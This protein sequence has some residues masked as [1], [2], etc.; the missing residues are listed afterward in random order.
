MLAQ[1]HQALADKI[2]AIANKLR[3]PYRPPQY[4]RVMLP[5]TVL[6]RL[7]CVLEPTKAQVLKQYEALQARGLKGEALDKAL[8]RA[9]A[10]DR[11]QPLYNVSPYTFAKLIGDP[12]GLARNLTAY[13]KGFSP[14]VREIFEKFEF[15]KEIEKL[16][17]A[18][19]LFEVIKIFAALD[20]H[21]DTVPNL[22]MGYVFENLIR[23]F[24]EQA[25][26]E[27]GDH[28]TPREVI[29]LMAHL[30]YT[31]D[32]DIH[33]AGISRTIY[34]PACGT[35]GM[36]SVSEEYIRSSN[37]DAHLTLYGQDYNAEAY[38]ICCADMLIKDEPAD[39]IVHGDT[40]GD[41]KSGDGHAGKTFHYMM[42]NP[43]FGVEW[44]TQEG[45]VKKENADHGFNGRFGPGLPRI[46]DGA[47][48]FLLHMIAKRKPSPDDGGE[49][50]KIAIVFN[51]SPLFTGDAGGGESNI[52]RWIIEND[53]LDAI[54]ALPDQLFYNTGIYT[55]VWMVTNR[56][57][58]KRRGKVQLI[59]ATRHFQK[60]KKSLGNKRNELS[61]EHIAGI[62]RLY[63][64][65]KHDAKAKFASN[66][67]TI[68]RVCSKV[69]DNREF[70]YLKLTIERPLRLNFQASIERILRLKDQSAFRALAESKKRK[71]KAEVEAEEEAGRELQE[72][73]ILAL[74]R[75][76]AK[77]LYK[78][79]DTFEADL[80][81]ALKAS[82]VRV[83]TPVRK[84]I[85]AALSE[86]DP[87]AEICR[88]GS[89]N[90]EPD[91]ELRD[92]ESVPLPADI[93]LPLPIGYED[94]ADNTDLVALVRDHCDAYFAK[95]VAPHWPDAWVDYSKTK[96]GYEIPINRHF[97]VYEPPRPLADIERDIKALEGEILQMLKEVV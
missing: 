72:S 61:E 31:G 87:D 80:D 76:N 95:E 50:S 11:K 51:G 58:K 43:P 18:N 82:E 60:M 20:L 22:A 10:K 2:W 97:Y 23:R 42:A 59:D 21:P 17:E 90:P 26:E 32:E 30:I 62:T 45:F 68:E 24:N 53:W 70:G 28:F 52:R 69:L 57:P 92:T 86:R 96:V 16:D 6:R 77:K 14:K 19:R 89:G 47:L 4:R 15:E 75:L 3:G 67:E 33:T 54:V 41:G 44:K 12:N 74:G 7:D 66:G 78:S 27:A 93:D 5:L 88:D 1:Q 73:I 36:L 56:K 8:A 39:N 37:P 48:L 29:R 13:I 79:R 25:N 64:A 71:D 63:A 9:A 35:G 81:K 83:A 94:K 85:L 84:A 34:D 91:S 65:G 55:Y 46:N 49:G 40:L 38:A